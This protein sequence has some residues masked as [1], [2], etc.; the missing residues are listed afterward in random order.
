M[1]L[2]VL[3][4]L[5]IFLLGVRLVFCIGLKSAKNNKIGKT[6]SPNFSN[7]KVLGY[8]KAQNNFPFFSIKTR[9]H[10]SPNFYNPIGK[11]KK[12]S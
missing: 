3:K 2:L 10:K 5:L 8:L 1:S 7:K 11:S 6:S 12:Q 9:Q 4:N